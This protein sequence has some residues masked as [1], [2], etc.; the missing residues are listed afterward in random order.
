[1]AF[2]SSKNFD[3]TDAPASKGDDY[4]LTNPMLAKENLHRVIVKKARKAGELPR[5]ASLIKY[6]QLGFQVD[7]R[8][9]SGPPILR[10]ASSNLR[11]ERPPAEKGKSETDKVEAGHPSASDL[12]DLEKVEE[13]GEYGKEKTDNLAPEQEVG[14]LELLAAFD[15]QAL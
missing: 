10:N 7:V 12:V 15:H 6:L 13:E 14:V 8:N 4:D 2:V 9:S 5:Q 3:N 1:M 11:I